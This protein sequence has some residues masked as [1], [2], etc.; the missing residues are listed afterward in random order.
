MDVYEM[1]GQN[2]HKTFGGFNANHVIMGSYGYYP[3]VR[4]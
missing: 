2:V 3:R 4:F 1:E